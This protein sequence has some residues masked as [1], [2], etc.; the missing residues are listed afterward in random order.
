[1]ADINEILPNG[2]I[3]PHSEYSDR[4]NKKL[5]SLL[6]MIGRYKDEHDRRNPIHHGT[7]EATYPY[8]LFEGSMYHGTD[9][10][11]IDR[12]YPS[13]YDNSMGL[14]VYLAADKG[15]AELFAKNVYSAHKLR[16]EKVG[17]PVVYEAKTR[18]KLALLDLTKDELFKDVVADF[19][20][21][22]N[23][24]GHEAAIDNSA[25]SM[26]NRA[27]WEGKVLDDMGRFVFSAFPEQFTEFLYRRG[28]DGIINGGENSKYAPFDKGVGTYTQIV[29][30]NPEDIEIKGS[31]KPES[32][33]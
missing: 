14:G 12:L 6:K 27:M 1:M 17:E 30:F 13:A 7:S 18:R 11:G 16:G 29:V 15:T 23:R 4:V 25:K 8:R 24:Y 2:D 20:I 32:K 3:V 19:R 28:Y 10:A 5:D 31:Y 22:V 26:A 21:Y 33:I 9:V